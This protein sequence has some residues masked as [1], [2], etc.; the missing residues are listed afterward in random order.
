M[1]RICSDKVES[2]RR[3]SMM[4]SAIV[5]RAWSFRSFECGERSFLILTSQLVPC[6]HQKYDCRVAHW[7][8]S[9]LRSAARPSIILVLFSKTAGTTTLFTA[10][11]TAFP[12]DC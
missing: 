6:A 8:I 3:R 11:P 4:L 7:T 12:S 1:D 9:D 5:L 10:S 2:C